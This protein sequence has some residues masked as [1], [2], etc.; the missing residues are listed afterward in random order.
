MLA[1]YKAVIAS[2]P[3]ENL[4]LKYRAANCAN[5]IGSGSESYS[6]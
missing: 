3:G 2:L 5:F 1:Y 4:E 6:G